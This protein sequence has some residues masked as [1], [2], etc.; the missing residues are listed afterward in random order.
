MWIP[1][2]KG[3]VEIGLSTDT[4]VNFWDTYNILAYTSVHQNED[5]VI[6]VSLL[7]RC[8][9]TYLRMPNLSH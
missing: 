8:L 2:F 3:T 4:I 5:S 1:L 6:V 7:S 9:Y